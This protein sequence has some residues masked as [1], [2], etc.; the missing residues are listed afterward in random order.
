MTMHSRSRTTLVI[1]L[2]GLSLTAAACGGD[3]DHHVDSG[4]GPPA[5][6]S[7]LTVHE[8]E[9][10][11]HLTWTDNS[12]NESEF[13]VMRMNVTD[14]GDYT[15]IASPPFD[16]TL[17]HDAIGLESGKD[18]MYTVYAMNDEGMSEGSNEVEFTAP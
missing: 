6:P 10:G 17:Y 1:W 9:G 15:M 3:D 18:Y 8:L 13:I 14:G 7:N 2:V 11:A 5:A 12:D 4:Q 16:T